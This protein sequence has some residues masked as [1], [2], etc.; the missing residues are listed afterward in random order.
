[1]KPGRSIRSKLMRFILVVSAGLLLVTSAAF[2]IYEILSYRQ[3]TTAQLHVL[4][5]IIASNSTAALAFESEPEATEILSALKAESNITSACLYTEKGEIF[6]TFPQTVDRDVLPE[7]PGEM[8]F[9]FNKGVLE[10]FVP[11]QQGDKKLGTLFIRRSTNDINERL[12]LYTAIVVTVI[13]LS[14]LLTYLLSKRLQKNISTP[15]I[16]LSE[17]ARM[18]SERHDYSVRAKTQSNDEIGLLTEA[19]NH[20]LS[21]IEVQNNEIQLAREAAQKH[22]QELEVKVNE[23]TIEYRKQKDFAEAVVASSLVM[24]AVFDKETRII[25]FNNKCEQE[26]GLKRENVVGKKLTEAMPAVKDSTTH[27]SLLAALDGEMVH[28]PLFKSSITGYFYETFLV[29][30]KNE[31]GDVYAALLTSH[32][33]SPLIEATENLTRINKELATKNAEL[34]QFA[35]I[36]SHDLQEP[37]RKIQTFIQLT[38]MSVENQQ[39]VLRYLDKTELSAQRMSNLIKDV[40]EYSRLSQIEESFAEIDLN[41]ILEFV[42]SDFELLISQRSATIQNDK[43]PFVKGN[44]LQLHQLFA[45]LIS[46]SIKF[47]DRKPEIKIKCESTLPDEITSVDHLDTNRNYARL[48]FI[49]NGIGFDPQYADKVFTIFQRLNTRE[50]YEGTGI[51]LALCKK[52]VENHKGNIKVTSAPGK[53]TTFTIYLPVQ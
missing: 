12:L 39:T 17:T 7:M 36:A 45:N 20:M 25:G 15:I 24:I 46:N 43:L 5:N 44:K 48:S 49:D 38:R 50:K 10:G 18:I 28:I 22:A 11:V 3:T 37:L 9:Y 21:Q 42:K 33:I 6:S 51:G 31:T 4:S 14:F 29:P 23:R 30:L 53:G 47:C 26:F 8:G 1:M 13:T 27:K 52:I 32:N 2:F 41:T 34:E 35:Y 19:F 40:L 16:S